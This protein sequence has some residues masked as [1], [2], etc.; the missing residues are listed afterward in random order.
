[1]LIVRGAGVV[2][3]SRAG[4]LP[5]RLIARLPWLLTLRRLLPGLL[6]R[7]RLL[8]WLL[9]WRWLLAGLLTRR[10][11]LTLWLPWRRLPGLLAGRRLLTWWRLALGRLLPGGLLTLLGR[12]VLRRLLT[13]WGLALAAAL[14]LTLTLAFVLVLVLVVLVFVLIRRL[15]LL[16]FGDLALH[17]VAVVLAVGVVG[18]ELERGLVGFDG[19]CPGFDRVLG[20]GLF[21]R[22]A[23]SI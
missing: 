10:R 7:R 2:A 1:M 4:R 16:E 8:T 15:L 6:A 22:L 12:L 23:G 13:G 21:G 5:L 3:F 19:V 18:F 9:P 11:L 20:C 17:E 14:A